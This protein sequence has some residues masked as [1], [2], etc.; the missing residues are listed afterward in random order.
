[1]YPLQYAASFLGISQGTLRNWI[2]QTNIQTITLTTDH[3][4]MYILHQDLI[5]LVV[6]HQRE[7]VPDTIINRPKN[8]F[9]L[10]V[11]V[12]LFEAFMVTLQ[13][14]LPEQSPVQ[15]SN[16]K[17]AEGVAVRVTTVPAA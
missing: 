12:T 11:A 13:A 16:R 8:H 7:I 10:N 17:F 4:R 6:T 3:E 15:L 5:K 1:M 2:A 9:L 14:P